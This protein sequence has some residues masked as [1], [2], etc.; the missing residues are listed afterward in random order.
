MSE[1]NLPPGV[2]SNQIPGNT[3]KDEASDKMISLLDDA[4]WIAVTWGYS[5][6][7]FLNEAKR[8][9][10]GAQ[11]QMDAAIADM[12]DEPDEWYDEHFYEAEE[13]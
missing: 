11:G 10:A 8:S 6:E 4:A 5:E 1:F 2:S 7:E 13:E 12:E 9:F 3:P